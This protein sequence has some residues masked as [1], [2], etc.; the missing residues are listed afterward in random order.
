MDM[1][2]D[3]QQ[4]EYDNLRA[5]EK[6]QRQIILVEEESAKTKTTS[7]LLD[8]YTNS[9]A[10]HKRRM[11]TLKRDYEEAMKREEAELKIAEQRLEAEQS[12]GVQKSKAQLRAEKELEEIVAKQQKFF[13]SLYPSNNST[14]PPPP[15]APQRAEPKKVNIKKDDSDSE[16]EDYDSENDDAPPILSEEPPQPPLT[17][18]RSA[19]RPRQSKPVESDSEDDKQS[20]MKAFFSDDSFRM[21]PAQRHFT[22]QYDVDRPRVIQNT[23]KM[24]KRAI[25]LSHNR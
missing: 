14:P 2:T 24:P 11:E 18:S 1:L 3:S 13:P 16:S 12:K 20:A 21:A 15:P 10:Y 25:S 17:Q 9:V 19:S 22:P 23:K 5:K 7:Y 6:K 4:K 8:R